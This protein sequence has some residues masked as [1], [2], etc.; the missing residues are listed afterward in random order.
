[1]A[2]PH[3]LSSQVDYQEAALLHFGGEHPSNAT[4]EDAVLSLTPQLVDV[5]DATI[6]VF[7]GGAGRVVVCGS[8]P[9]SPNPDG[10]AW[11]AEHTAVVYVMPRGHGH[12]SPVRDPA[13]MR[14]GAVARDLEA[15]RR[16]LGIERWV[17][18]GGSGGSQLA[19]TYALAYPEALAGLIIGFS[20]ADIAGALSDPRTVLSPTHPAYQADLTAA[21]LDPNAATADEE[22]H[23]L[24]LRPDLWALV[25]GERPLF[26]S[27]W[28]DLSP[29]QRAHFEEIV[30]FDLSARLREVRAPTLVVC[31]R[32][33][34]VVPCE[35]CVAMHQGIP[36]SEV[37]VL[38]HSPH[39]V[40]E[41]DVP[42][43]RETV[44]RFL[45]RLTGERT[46]WP[47]R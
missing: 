16:A 2:L 5:W 41:A 40:A 18:Q 26:M 25:Q 24:Q 15:V 6:E 38:E 34:P 44:R 43:F 17:V 42:V 31:G 3:L 47:A 27:P 8:H 46:S 39:G 32:V 12:S 9:H 1:M 10:F 22:P 30:Q 33:D 21:D 7:R 14:V 35:R 19:L 20:A 28:P 29:H 37:L 4:Q 11:Y 23:W 13:D 45:A 36:G